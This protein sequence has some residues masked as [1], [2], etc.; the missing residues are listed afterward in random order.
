[1]RFLHTSDW[2]LG[3][4][5]EGRSRIEEQRAVLDSLI[6]TVEKENIEVVL[7][8]GDVYDSFTPSAEAEQLF[9]D[10]VF[11]LSSLKVVT[12]IISGNHD[13]PTRLCASQKLAMLSN[14]WFSDCERGEFIIDDGAKAYAVDGGR[15]YLIVENAKKE[16]A[17]IALLPY[18][19]ELRMR[20]RVQAE[21]TYEDKVAR[22]VRS[23]LEANT[24]R[25]PAILCAH[26]FMLGGQ[27]GASE[28]AI[29]LGGA[30]ILPP[31]VIPDQVVYTALGHIHKRQVVNA[32]RNMIY[33]GSIFQC[34]FDERNY[35]KSVTVFDL[36]DGKIENLKCVE[37]KGYKRLLSFT[38]EG[39]EAGLSLLDGHDDTFVELNLILNQ[40]LTS[41]MTR[42][43]VTKHPNVFLRTQLNVAAGERTQS[44]K[45]MTD[46]QLF[47]NFYTQLYGEAPDEEIKSLYLSLV[48]DEVEE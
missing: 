39:Y 2:H 42:E 25:L 3:K 10:V 37:L 4:K 27:A 26:V 46:E 28:R 35:Q 38:A 48:A 30:R 32:E 6:E 8:C 45:T 5:L 7:I 41:E 24:E 14:V 44:R 31:S 43:I 21:E 20:E 12:V 47:V 18:P 36:T 1:M 16:R 40:P 22:Y 15:D 23:A 17:Y 33:C 13:D 29:E 34:A 11:R 9:F 19:T